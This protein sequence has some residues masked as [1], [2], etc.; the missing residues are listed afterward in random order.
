VLITQFCDISNSKPSN[1]RIFRD[2][3]SSAIVAQIA[4]F[5]SRHILQVALFLSKVF[6]YR[7]ER[8]IGFDGVHNECY[9][10]GLP[11]EVS[12]KTLLLA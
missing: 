6:E 2:L 12:T 1:C 8:E 3:H 10:F 9:I 7:V 5:V 4:A 11:T